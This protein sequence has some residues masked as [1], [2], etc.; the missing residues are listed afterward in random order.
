MP[1]SSKRYEIVGSSVLQSD[2]GCPL[3]L[4]SAA[5]N[6][7][8]FAVE[9][10]R[11]LADGEVSGRLELLGERRRARSRPQL[12]AFRHGL[13]RMREDHRCGLDQLVHRMR[14]GRE[15]ARV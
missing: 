7:L 6:A 8:A 1:S 3:I 14:S 5:G 11:A 15:D 4:R 9:L 10:H 13:I 12:S 2:E